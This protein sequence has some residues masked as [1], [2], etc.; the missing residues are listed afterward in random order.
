MTESATRRAG[1]E[2]FT[3][4][5]RRLA[6]EGNVRRIVVKDTEDRVVLDVPVNAGLVAAVLAPV[7]TAAG[8]IA[9]LAGPWSI[10]IERRGGP[11]AEEGP[12]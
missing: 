6:R 8:A 1:R 7:V 11:T 2:V 3:E 10:A 9:A 12:S 5:V 4:K